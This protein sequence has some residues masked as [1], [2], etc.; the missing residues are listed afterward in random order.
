[1]R[2]RNGIQTLYLFGEG[3]GT[4]V[5][6]SAGFNTPLHLEIRNPNAVQWLPGGGLRV[7][8]PTVI[9]SSRPATRLAGACRTTHQLTLEAWIRPANLTQYGPARIV[10]MSKGTKLRN[11]TLGQQERA[12][13]FRIGTSATW[14][15]ALPAVYA[16]DTAKL[17]GITHVVCTFNTDGVATVF[18]DGTRRRLGVHEKRRIGGDQPLGARK[19]PAAY[20]T[21]LRSGSAPE[22]P[23]GGNLS[24]WDESLDLALAEEIDLVPGTTR[25]WL[26]EYY[27]VALYNR[28]LQEWEIARNH[29]AGPHPDSASQTATR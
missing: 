28:A 15:V 11:F 2:T 12:Y 16:P 3:S 18:V 17:A 10:T 8:A 21:A 14:P 19:D 5:R 23:V 6:D 13:E 24:A 9:R 20:A 1:M 29:R 25:C 27:L 7:H 26:G 4:R 22:F